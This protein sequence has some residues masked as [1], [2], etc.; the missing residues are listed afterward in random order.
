MKK[1]SSVFI[2]T[3]CVALLC[4]WQQANAQTG[5]PKTFELATP[6]QPKTLSLKAIPL[7]DVTINKQAVKAFKKSGV[8]NPNNNTP[9]NPDS[10]LTF[11]TKSNGKVNTIKIKAGEYYDQLNAT[12][13]GY[14]DIGYSVYDGDDVSG[15]DKRVKNPVKLQVQKMD[16]NKLTSQVSL[17][18]KSTNV[19]TAS[20][21]TKATYG[22]NSLK[23]KS[24]TLM[25]ETQQIKPG[26]VPKTIS[27]N[28]TKRWDF[29]DKSTFQAFLEVQMKTSGSFFPTAK[30]GE[31][32]K[33]DECKLH[34]EGTAGAC[35]L[36][37]EFD[38]LNAKAHFHLPPNDGD[39]TA[40]VQVDVIG[41]TVYDLDETQKVSWSREKDYHKDLNVNVPFIVPLGPINVKGEVG[42]KGS[43]GVKYDVLLNRA[44]VSGSVTPYVKVTGYGEAGVDILIAGAG[45]GASLTVCEADVTMSASALVAWNG[46]K[47]SLIDEF[48]ID[49]DVT[50][51]SGRVYCFAYVMVPRF[52]LPPWKEKRFEHDFFSWDGYKK[53][54]NIIHFQNSTPLPY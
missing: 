13:K 17:A 52:G 1:N 3:F 5:K 14:N 42:I 33:N 37:Q 8:L 51:L 28:E 20:S 41:I 40:S 35:I 45:V 46:P 7:S 26:L 49:Y 30:Q 27:H 43:A 16:M 34:V 24:P 44:G 36:K 54:G 22:T 25:L 23:A 10:I 19:K 21:V 53:S 38:V 9:T 4:S 31:V 12:E 39:L 2:A 50:F 48:D 15:D 11:T 29:G 32:S 47:L 18:P 6:L